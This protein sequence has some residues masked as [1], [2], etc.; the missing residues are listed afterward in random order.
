MAPAYQRL[1]FRPPYPTWPF[2]PG[3]L[4]LQGISPRQLLKF[5]YEHVRSCLERG[6]ATEYRGP[7]AGREPAPVIVPSDRFVGID[8]KFIAYRQQADPAS[9]LA[10]QMDD[11]RL[12]P[13]LQAACRCLVLENRLPPHLSTVVDVDFH[14][15]KTTRPLHV[16]LRLIHLDEGD[17]EE[18][19]CLRAI[20]RA[21][22]RAF[23]ARLNAAMIQAGIDRRLGFRRLAI[24]R[25]SATPGGQVTGELVKKFKQSGGVFLIPSEDDLRTLWRVSRIDQERDP[26]FADWLRE[27]KPVSRLPLMRGAAP[28]LCT[29]GEQATPT[30]GETA[31]PKG[32]DVAPRDRPTDARAEG[33]RR[34]LCP[35]LCKPLQLYSH[36]PA[37]RST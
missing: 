11:E 18:H 34:D 9:M 8:E 4:D 27:R 35:P 29:D 36:Q 17:R 14:G 25:S 1:G 31:Q 26:S 12:A 23:Q 20:Q 3:S 32:P 16:R 24:V 19:F 21:H 6:K 28:P 7:A 22:P 2:D 5:A 13:L 30:I 33:R 15:G 37:L 10:E